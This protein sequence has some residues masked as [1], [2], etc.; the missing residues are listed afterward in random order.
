M[1]SLM[2]YYYYWY[3]SSINSKID[4]LRDLLVGPDSKLQK[5]AVLKKAINYI[6]FLTN[7]NRRLKYENHLLRKHLASND[8]CKYDVIIYYMQGLRHNACMM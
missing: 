3:R 4:E 7:A 2:T 8:A 1:T 6:N 5:A